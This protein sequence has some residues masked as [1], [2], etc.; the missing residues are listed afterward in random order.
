[1]RARTGVT[2]RGFEI[3]ICQAQVPGGSE[4]MCFFLL[5]LG[6][7]LSICRGLIEQVKIPT[8]QDVD[9]FAQDNEVVKVK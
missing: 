5:R 9:G 8:R 3:V 6:Q 1:M 7:E 4:A 2:V